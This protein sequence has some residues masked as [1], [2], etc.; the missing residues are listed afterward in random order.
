MLDGYWDLAERLNEAFL[1]A[2]LPPFDPDK[3]A[4]EFSGGERIR[5]LLCGAFTAEANFLLLDEPTNHLDRQ[6]RAWFYD[7][8][9]H[10]QGGVLVASRS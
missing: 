5:A 8:L 10:Y 4:A 9:S 7:Q 2:K 3:P 1:R 6:G